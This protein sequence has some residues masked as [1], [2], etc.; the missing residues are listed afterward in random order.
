MNFNINS[1]FDYLVAA[2]N[3]IK[4]CKV[5]SKSMVNNLKIQ[6]SVVPIECH[7]TPNVTVYKTRI[8]EHD[9]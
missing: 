1:S 6:H 5:R 8:V 4:N 3:W 7:E 9:D 2:K